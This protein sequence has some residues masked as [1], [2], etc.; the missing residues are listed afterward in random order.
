MKNTVIS[1]S[2]AYLQGQWVL[3]NERL[4]LWLPVCF[5]IGVGIYFSLL[6][7]P[8]IDHV[9]TL[10]AVS[11]GFGL[12]AFA[13][14]GRKTRLLI[15]PLIAS[16]FILM[17]FAAAALQA[18]SLAAPLLLKKLNAV[19]LQGTVID[20]EP[21]KKNGHRVMIDGVVLDK[22]PSEGLSPQRV[23]LS[24]RH[25][26]KVGIG[27]HIRVRASLM[28]PSPPVL[29][30][31][32]DFQ[33][34]AYFD[35]FGAVGYTLGQ[36]EIIAHTEQGAAVDTI[37]H[38][39]TSRVN[40]VLEG[41]SAAIVKALLT[42]QRQGIS[43]D[44]LDAL[45][46]AGL[47]HLLAIS[48]LHIGMVAGLFFVGLRFVMACIPSLALQYP[49]K[50]IAAIVAV[51]AAFSY[52]LLAGATIPTIRAFIMTGLVL[53]AVIMDRTALTLRLVAVAAMVILILNPMA[54]T[55]VS[56][57]LSFAAVLALIAFYEGIGRRFVHAQARAGLLQKLPLYFLGIIVTSVV[58][59]LAT[60]P[61]AFYYF[62]RLPVWGVAGNLAAIPLM[63]FW[64][65]PSGLIALLAMPFGLEALPLKLMGQGVDWISHAAHSISSWPYALWRM[66]SFPAAYFI[67]CSFGFVFLCLWRGVLRWGGLL[68]MLVT[69]VMAPKQNMTQILIADDASAVAIYDNQQVYL[70]GVRPSNYVF[71]QWL[72][73]WGLDEQRISVKTVDCDGL[74]CG[75]VVDGVRVIHS[76]TPLSHWDDC[77]HADIII[78]ADPFAEAL[79]CD[80]GLLIDR[81]D[82]WR[83]G[84]MA[85]RIKDGKLVQHDTVGGNRGYRYWTRDGQINMYG[86]GRLIPLAP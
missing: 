16:A 1:K 41:D 81:F 78:A 49:I 64:V 82:V 38:S 59:S 11:L 27:D 68:L 79:I 74:G 20:I 50:K 34:K 54:V 66:P 52:M 4:I 39:I 14:V 84:A 13:S 24:S 12:C 36:P 7:E 86:K 6:F 32:F 33:K 83:D 21:G 60:L 35:G 18:R 85:L 17:G 47:A 80:A 9:L 23:R 46:H 3:Q 48:G 10:L 29:P 58:A 43:T 15:I 77:R 31:G 26:D 8:A 40:A 37:R 5:A 22:M 25:F 56:F 76:Q 2:F 42:G 30:G 28:P 57:Q 44:R 72:E 67:L 63:G 51:L 62:N 70:S 53:V 73:D 71:G 65:M 69:L 55:G 45:R 61:F 75:F 19:M